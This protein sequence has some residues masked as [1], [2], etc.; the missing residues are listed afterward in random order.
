MWFQP[1]FMDRGS[2]GNTGPSPR[3]FH[4]A[5]SI[6]CYMFIFGGRSGANRYLVNYGS[7][8]SLLYNY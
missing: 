3:A 4:V 2:D 7:E 8:A 6:D 5:V 1:E